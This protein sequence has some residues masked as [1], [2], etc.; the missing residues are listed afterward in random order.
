MLVHSRG[1]T[2]YKYRRQS[3]Q[4]GT[5]TSQMSALSTAQSGISGAE[6]RMWACFLLEWVTNLW[7]ISAG[8]S[9]TVCETADVHK[10]TEHNYTFAVT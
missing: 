8:V 4:L 1:S 2:K 6:V 3:L 10:V 5:V 9:Q 7:A